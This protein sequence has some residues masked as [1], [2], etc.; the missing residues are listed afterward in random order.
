M[1]TTKEAL[2]KLSEILNTLTDSSDKEALSF[3][4]LRVQAAPEIKRYRVTGNIAG[5]RELKTEVTVLADGV[6]S[7]MHNG[8]IAMLKDYQGKRNIE[9]IHVEELPDEHEAKQ[10]E[11]FSRP[12]F[13]F[14]S[15][16]GDYPHLCSG[17]LVIRDVTTDTVYHLQ[18]ALQSGGR[19]NYYGGDKQECIQGPWFV[20]DDALPIALT[21]YVDEI[22]ELV[23]ANV[24]HGCCGGCFLR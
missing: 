6:S 18:N 3:A 21:P 14:I 24:E 13:E 23:N 12:R 1:L 15:Y 7:A 5:D 11:F 16:S 17:E 10:T 2:R 8:T 9:N 19:C 22:T 4:I 20:I